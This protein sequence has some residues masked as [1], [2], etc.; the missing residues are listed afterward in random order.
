[1]G[2]IDKVKTSK[3][4]G[5]NVNTN[6]DVTANVKIGVKI[7]KRGGGGYLFESLD[8]NYCYD[9]SLFFYSGYFS[10]L[11][12]FK[13]IRFLLINDTWLVAKSFY[14]SRMKRHIRRNNEL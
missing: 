1:M 2:K 9:N 3:K 4:S 7:G 10:N 6:L 12:V 11:L 8:S 5:H 13:F 14:L